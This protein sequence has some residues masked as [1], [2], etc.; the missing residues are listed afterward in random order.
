MSEAEVRRE[1]LAGV[2]PGREALFAPGV[3]GERRR[4]KQ[5]DRPVPA[6]SYYGRPVIKAPAWEPRD[7]AGYLFLGGLAGAGS[8]LAA[9]AQLTGRAA[10][11]RAM[12]LS[13]LSAV[14]LSVAALV[15]DLGRPARFG[16]ML[17]VV[18]PTSPMSVG[19]WLLAGYGPLAGAAAVSELTG[20]APRAGRAATAGAA[21]LGPAVAAYTGVL[22]ADTAVPAW[23]TA[24]RE[25]P[26]VFVGSAA[27][28]AAGMALLAGPRAENRPARRAAVLGTVTELAALGAARRRAGVVAETYEGGP[29]GRLLAAAR[30]LGVAGAAA[31]W[32]LG[33]RSRTVAAVSGAALLASSACTRFGIFHAG[34]ASARD[35]KYTVLPQRERLAA[36]SGL[37]EQAAGVRAVLDDGTAGGE[38]AGPPPD[39]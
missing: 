21:C 25:L 28:A 33:G 24:H 11:A 31:G 16:N 39:A 38:V 32:L 9:G 30:R 23:H 19:S 15:N 2:R 22:I 37:A 1:G 4:R 3:D 10:T 14:S 13:S 17:R 8:V 29:A 26:Y 6:E 20:R 27:A 12:K 5:G 18:K 7:I 36:R 34:L 35:P